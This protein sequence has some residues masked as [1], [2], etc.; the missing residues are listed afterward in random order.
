M[1]WGFTGSWV[2][3]R[4][5]GLGIF[6]VLSDFGLPAAALGFHNSHLKTRTL[7]QPCLQGVKVT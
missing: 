7:C 1:L 3:G 2:S 6:G 5:T 4:Q